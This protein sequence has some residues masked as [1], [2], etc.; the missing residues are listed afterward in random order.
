MV[1]VEFAPAFGL[2]D[3]RPV[4]GAVAGAGESGC[5]DEGLGQDGGVAV[6]GPPVG[7]Q[8]AGDGGEEAGGEVGDLDV[9]ADEE[10]GVAADKVQVRFAGGGVPADAGVAGGAFPGAGGEGEGGDVAGGGAGGEVA[11]LGAGQRGVA[12]VVVVADELVPLPGLGAAADNADGDRAEIGQGGGGVGVVSS[13]RVSWP[14]VSA[15]RAWRPLPLPLRGGGR[16][17][18]W[19][20][21]ILARATRA[22]MSLGRPPGACQPSASQTAREIAARLGSLAASP[23]MTASSAGVK[24]RPQ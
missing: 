7:G 15:W 12:E 11:D 10:P 17:I 16:V 14:S 4:G 19:S 5:F 2:A 20:A 21:A 23:A 24:S 3:A 18:R 6:A 8:A 22:V 9:G 1:A 13:G